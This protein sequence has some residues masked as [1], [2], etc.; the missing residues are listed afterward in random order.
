MSGRLP[1]SHFL[2]TAV[3]IQLETQ[4]IS[5]LSF[6]EKNVVPLLYDIGLKLLSSS[7]C[8]SFHFTMH[9]GFSVG[10]GS[11]GQEAISATIIFNNT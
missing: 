3:H 1:E 10:Q 5:C 11:G 7:G 9:Q 4:E 2:L 8:C 6:F